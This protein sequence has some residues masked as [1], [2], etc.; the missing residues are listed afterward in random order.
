MILSEKSATF[1]D[2]ALESETMYQ[3]FDDVIAPGSSGDRLKALRR[4]LKSRKL[5]GFLVPHSDE[6]QNEFLS[7]PAERLAWLT[8]FSGSAGTAIVLEDSAALFVDGGYF[9]Q[10]RAQAHPP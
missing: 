2:H 4:K 9:L 3:S 6:Y 8:G 10:A 7:P 1:P 5:Q